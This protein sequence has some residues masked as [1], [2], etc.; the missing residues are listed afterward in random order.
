MACIEGWRNSRQLSF[1]FG[2]IQ[3]HTHVYYDVGAELY[4]VAD[5]S[6]MQHKPPF[7]SYV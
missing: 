7:S 3:L 2:Q 6:I 5:I 1:P 4:C